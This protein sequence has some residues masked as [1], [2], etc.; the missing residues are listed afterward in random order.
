MTDTGPMDIL[1]VSKDKTRL[2]VLELKR[3]RTSDA[4]VGQIQRYMGYV[5][6]ELLEA[7]QT[8]EGIIIAGEDDIRI[9]RALRMNANIRFLKYRINF[10]LES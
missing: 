1:A 10:H 4:V 6:D 5:H 8:V 9:T 2:L 7:G 3:G